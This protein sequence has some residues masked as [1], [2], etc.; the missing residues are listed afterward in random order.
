MLAKKIALAFGIAVVFPAMI[1][2]AVSIFSPPPRWEDYAVAPTTEP[3]SSEWRE[4]R[5]EKE[6]GRKAAEKAFEKHLF[7]VAVPL[8]LAAIIAG[9]FFFGPAIGA[10]L[11]F[12]GIF[13]VCNG[14]FNYWSELSATLRFLSLLVAFIVLILVGYR[15]IERK[16]I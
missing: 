10:G 9:A 14:Y 13:S 7:A 12:G 15:K 5:T 11:M 1:Y 8:G 4:K 6:T 16:E 3:N 2:C